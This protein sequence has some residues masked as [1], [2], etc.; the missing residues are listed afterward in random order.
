MEK[1]S[2]RTCFKNLAHGED[3]GVRGKRDS[4]GCARKTFVSQV[5]R[6]GYMSYTITSFARVG[7]GKI[8][9]P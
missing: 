3:I 6:A 5:E 7:E 9:L 4:I 2:L 8:V 1:L